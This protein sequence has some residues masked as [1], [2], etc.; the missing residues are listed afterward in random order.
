MLTTSRLPTLRFITEGQ[1]TIA[2]SENPRAGETI[3]HW[4]DGTI[5]QRIQ[6]ID[7][8]PATAW[9]PA[10]DGVVVQEGGVIRADMQGRNPY[11]YAIGPNNNIEVRVAASDEDITR[12]R[13]V[14][15]HEVADIE[16]PQQ[17][18]TV[19]SVITGEAII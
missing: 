3:T 15:L 8:V 5:D 6:N 9:H 13:Q 18:T 1:Y 11:Q 4:L 16:D 12:I 7:F 19:S 10:N 14:R 17:A 2:D